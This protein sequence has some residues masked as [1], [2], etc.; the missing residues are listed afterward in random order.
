M[1][2]K[3]RPESGADTRP[4][5]RPAASRQCSRCGLRFH[6]AGFAAD[7]SRKRG[8]MLQ[9]WC[10][11][12]KW[13]V[14]QGPEYAYSRCLQKQIEPSSRSAWTFAIYLAEIWKDGTCHY[15]G[16]G[17]RRWQGSGHNLD[18]VDNDRPHV[19][20]NCVAACAACNRQKGNRHPSVYRTEVDAHVAAWGR[21][22][23]PWAKL[24]EDVQ[25]NTPPDMSIFMPREEQ[26]ALFGDERVA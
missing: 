10:R 8:P 19:P 2:R 14:E 5:L 20:D 15:C 11:L 6:P 16:A 4:E 3:R 18:R 13:I 25:E 7:R 26:I 22:R 9:S 24:R 1:A 12:C 21:G 23:V 17:L